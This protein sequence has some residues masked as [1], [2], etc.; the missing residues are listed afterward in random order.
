M[1]V[2]RRRR[3]QR[4]SVIFN[5]VAK[6]Y[7][8]CR[9]KHQAVA[10]L[11]TKDPKFR[12]FCKGLEQSEEQLKRRVAVLVKVDEELMAAFSRIT[13]LES[14]LKS[15]EEEL[16]ISR[17]V[18]AEAADL[19]TRVAALTAELD[20]RAAE[21]EVLKRTAPPRFYEDVHREAHEMWVYA[22]ARLVVLKEYLAA[23]RATEAKV[24]EQRR[25]AVPPVKPVGIASTL[26][27]GPAI[28]P[29]TPT[30]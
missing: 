2:K 12:V 10:D 11:L 14:L 4:K 29:R 26:Q 23:G 22:E 28:T 24:Q 13:E 27:I 16:E 1:E 6:K 8:K 20:A 5:K 7:K 9:A 30:G 19:Q 25:V 15:R 17:G 3:A 21:N 18:A